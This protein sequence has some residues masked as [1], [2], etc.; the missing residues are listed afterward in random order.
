MTKILRYKMC[1]VVILGLT[2]LTSACS[3]VSQSVRWL[4]SMAQTGWFIV[5][6]LLLSI[7]A[8]GKV[9]NLIRIVLQ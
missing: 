6:L 1:N 9:I 3:Q 4:T 2:D 7:F 5:P 8:V